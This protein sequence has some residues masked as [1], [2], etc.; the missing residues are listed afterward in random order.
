MPFEEEPLDDEVEEIRELI[1]EIL[2]EFPT[3]IT[4]TFLEQKYMERYVTKGLAKPLPRNWLSLMRSTEEFELKDVSTFTML[5]LVQTTKPKSVL[6]VS[7]QPRLTVTEHSNGNA[8][9]DGAIL[10][11][12]ESAEAKASES[13]VSSVVVRFNSDEFDPIPLNGLPQSNGD[14]VPI[15][16][17]SAID[18]DAIYFRLAVWV[19]YCEYL[20]AALSRLPSINN[21]EPKI[22]EILAAEVNGRWERVEMIRPSSAD[23]N[24]WVVLVVD[25]GYFHAVHHNQLRPLTETVTAFNKI[26]LAKCKLETGTDGQ[27]RGWSAEVQHFVSESLRKVAMRSDCRVELLLQKGGSWEYA[28]GGKIPT[29]TAKL[30]IDGADFAAQMALMGIG[31]SK[32]ME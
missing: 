1:Y 25:E 28:E 15:R 2:K 6:S 26:F 13:A 5:Y 17:I 24:F 4:S 9:D 29:C 20:Y 21:L 11:R 31:H 19:P 18:P 30:L 3:G 22:G 14:P 12:M 23:P 16:L 7:L 10:C 32:A 8:V 27:G